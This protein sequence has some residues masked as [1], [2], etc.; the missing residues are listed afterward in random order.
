M[1]GACPLTLS[2]GATTAQQSTLLPLAVALGH[3]RERY[4]WQLFYWPGTV[5]LCACVFLCVC[6]CACACV[7]KNRCYCPLAA[8]TRLSIVVPS[9]LRFAASPVKVRAS[10]RW[11]RASPSFFVVCTS[12]STRALHREGSPEDKTRATLQLS[13]KGGSHATVFLRPDEANPHS[14]DRVAVCL[15]YAGVC[16]CG[17]VCGTLCCV[18][19]R[20]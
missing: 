7:Q 8:S 2:V 13:Q 10:C 9:I 6:V 14:D 17:Y 5:Q 3:C 20:W 15:L 18:D 4:S 19:V 1:G 12:E 16:T 11:C